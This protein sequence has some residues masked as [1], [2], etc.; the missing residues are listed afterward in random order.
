MSLDKMKTKTEMANQLRLISNQIWDFR[1]ANYS[2]LTQAK[3]KQVAAAS[4]KLAQRADEVLQDALEEGTEQAQE[5]IDK[6]TKVTNKIKKAV[7]KIEK[8]EEIIDI[9]V[10]ISKIAAAVVSMG[11]VSGDKLFDELIEVGNLFE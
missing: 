7:N 1:V 4:L 9:A 6:L 3:R 10:K 5:L 11:T 8:V 2:K